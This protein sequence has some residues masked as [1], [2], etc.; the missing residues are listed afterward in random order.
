MKTIAKEGADAF[1]DGGSMTKTLVD[2]IRNAGGII[3]TEDF[4]SYEPKWGKPSITELFN[5]DSF[6][7][8]PLPSTG[9]VIKFIMN[10]LKGYKFEERSFEAHNEDKLIYHRIMEAFK[11]G[12]AKRTKLGDESTAEV[13]ETLAE[14]ESSEY[15]DL[16]R[17]LITDDKTFNDYEHYGANTTLPEDHGTS[18][19]SIIAPNGD[20]VALTT[21]INF[22]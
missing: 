15:A 7:T 19:I 20:A 4:T 11:Y 17:S 13:L 18:H 21:T 3:T 8:F 5:G 6:Y 1:Y 2:E 10:I 9:P 12:F 22:M 14:L 16:I